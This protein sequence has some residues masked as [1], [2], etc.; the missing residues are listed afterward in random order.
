M[1]W[2]NAVAWAAAL[3]HGGLS[4]WWLPMPDT[5]PSSNCSLNYDP[6]GGFPLQYY[7]LNCTGSEMGHHFYNALGGNANESVLTQTGD[8]A[9]EI[10]N[11][12]L[13]TNVQPD[14]YWLGASFAPDPQE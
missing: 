2:D 9:Q 6:G 4:D 1:T 12:A 8:T 7:S 5:G 13:F 10:T 11:L 3:V 14:V